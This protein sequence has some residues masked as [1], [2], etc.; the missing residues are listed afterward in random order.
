ML[1]SANLVKEEEE[2]GWIQCES[3]AC[4][5]KF[6]LNN[7]NKFLHNLKA[8]IIYKPIYN[9]II[10]FLPYYITLHCTVVC[11]GGKYRKPLKWF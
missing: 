10:L 1:L 11:W 5:E 8:V 3:C 2:E 9:F 7:K 4:V 6:T